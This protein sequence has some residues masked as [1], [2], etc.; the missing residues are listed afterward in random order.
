[1]K[2]ADGQHLFAARAH[3]R[4]SDRGYDPSGAGKTRMGEDERSIAEVDRRGFFEERIDGGRPHLCAL[5]LVEFFPPARRRH[6]TR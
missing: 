2:N 1:M 5:V 6:R 3:D 4:A